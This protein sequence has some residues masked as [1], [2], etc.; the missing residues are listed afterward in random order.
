MDAEK[1]FDG[2]KWPFLFQ[3]ISEMNFGTKFINSVK[4]LYRA[5][6]VQI[7]TNGVLSRP[8]YPKRGTRQGCPVSSLLL[9]LVVEPQAVAIRLNPNINGI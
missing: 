7:A 1:A 4:T 3:T 2:I 6:K 5:P 9:A 8:I